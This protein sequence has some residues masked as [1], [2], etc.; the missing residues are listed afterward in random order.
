LRLRTR[1][2]DTVQLIKE[3]YPLC[4]RKMLQ[5]VRAVDAINAAVFPWPR[6]AKVCHSVYA[7][8]LERVN[9]KIARF[10]VLSAPKIKQ[11]LF[12]HRLSLCE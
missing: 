4:S 11:Y 8:K 9:A 7:F 1:L 6:L 10:F 12:D 5:E 3:M 2:Q